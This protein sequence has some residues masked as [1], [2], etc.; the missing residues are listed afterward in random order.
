M[1]ST[2]NGL[3]PY[4]CVFSAFLR[5]A[6]VQR[7]AFRVLGISLVLFLVYCP[8]F[9][10]TNTGRILGTVLDQTGAVVSGARV[11]ISDT[12]RGTSRTLTTD[13][14]GE[15][16]APSL[17]PSVYKVTAESPSFKKTER[18]TIEVQVARDVRVDFQLQPGA[19]S[20]VV[21]VTDMAPLVETTNDVLG[22]TFT[23][24]AINDLPLNGRDFQNLV[25][26]RPGVQRFPGGG[27]LSISS[28]GNRPEDNNFIVD[29]T[30]G[31]DPY[32]STTVI[33]A[34]GVQG[35]PATHLPIDAIQEFNAEENPPA[36]YGWK[37]GAIVNVGLKSGTND[38][39]GTA[40]Y[41]DRN[42]AFDA[43]N[44]FNKA[45]APQKAV[46]LHQFGATVGGP[47]VRNR[48]FYFLAYEGTRDLVSN[49]EV[50]PSPA[51]ISIGDPSLSIPDAIASVQTHGL[52]PSPLSTT[53]AA[54]FPDNDGTNP[55]G[56][57]NVT[58]GFP[59]TN[60]EDNGL[61]KMDYHVSE[62]HVLTGRYFI[63]DS[64]QTEEDIPVL[65]PE[66]QSQ[67]VTRAQLVGINWTWT[68]SSRWVNEAKFGYNRFS[69]P[70]LTVDHNRSPQSYGINTGVT[71]SVNFG[72]PEI[73]VSGF[74][75]LGGNHGWPLLT[76]PN[77]TYQFIDNVSYTR[78]AHAIKFGGE[79]RRGSTHNIRDRFGKGR[80]RF[81][82]GNAFSSSSPL[83]DFIAGFPSKGRIFVGNSERHANI[84][85]FG[86]F[87]QDDWRLSPRFALNL[88]LRYDLSTVIKEQNNLLGNFDP[89]V[90]LV[91]V[92]RDVSSPYNG[93]HNNFAPRVGIIWDPTS[94]SKTVVR[95][96]AGIMYEIPH[97][98]LF[99]GQNG[100]DNASTTGL[101]VVPTGA[102]GVVPGGGKIV[103]AATNT[104][105][106]NWTTAG[107]VFNTSA[108]DCSAVP[109][110]I[111][112]VNH[113][114]RTPYVANWNLNVQQALTSNTALQ[115]GYVGSKGTKLYSVYDINQ[116]DP[117][118]LAEKACSHCEQAGRPF[119]T[120]FP[121]LEF[122]NFLT[123]GYES[124]YNALQATLTQRVSHGLAFVAGYSWAH[125]LDQ[126]T[127]NR[128][129]Q[130]Q[131]ST[132]P[133]KEYGNGDLDLRHRFT[134]SVTYELPGR[135]SWAQMLEG[136]QI[137][138]I[139][140][141][142]T[143]QP[144]GV[145]DGFQSGNDISL[146]GE[147]VDRWNFFGNPSDFSVSP[148]GPIPFFAPSTFGIDPVTNQAFGNSACLAHASV[149]ALS[150]FG[151]Y[152]Q[153]SGVLVPPA[154]GH[155][156]TM[157]RNTFRGPG[158][159]NWDLSV[160]KTWKLTEHVNV[161]LRGEFFNILNHPN[162]SNPFGLEGALGNVDPSVPSS[163]GFTSVTPDVAAANPVIGTGGP[164]EIQLG[165]KFLF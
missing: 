143:G 111:L 127:L 19:A 163:F 141:L 165:L 16:V 154:P 160:V 142:Q 129:V 44:W 158:Y 70:I 23:N 64:V 20:E 69:Q 53:L 25:V 32:Y 35:T 28:N 78:G 153:G 14:S 116:V 128:D 99:L 121:F 159:H 51:T 68:A 60:R 114:L 2:D 67:A 52:T 56:P 72:M 156:G 22:G 63:G 151:C 10:Q 122:I 77:Q 139:L 107:P 15:Y 147:F 58:L 87:I 117:N 89:N 131:D 134:L 49:S 132:H 93:D 86:A 36:E 103:A 39:H 21:E 83:E 84:K 30:D 81:T 3:K 161:Q 157:G 75:S 5:V 34:E 104:S 135:K 140:I 148:N 100:V 119:N 6:R 33:N 48:L 120:K 31:N 130:P 123:N 43:R 24:K 124:N 92:G 61:A 29:G 91:Q 65:R 113:N 144:W 55:A 137:N 11:V 45:P 126:G 38:I 71:Q 98:S 125:A 13:T 110:D 76:T 85:A 95:A 66:W 97:M 17:V 12:Q 41:F 138:S 96:G 40:Y 8:L 115:V 59:N 42:N 149:S 82:G 80:I 18:P 152:V 145:I 118:S 155:F 50:I 150:S 108:L 133:E 26:L 9:S 102:Q 136:W 94:K 90:G 162:F 37:P 105:A 79:F 109:C 7:K 47:V 1:R 46:R 112:G 73:A 164:R 62:R 74:T 88:G 57:G 27:F 106:L 54:L 4:L 146:T 101:N